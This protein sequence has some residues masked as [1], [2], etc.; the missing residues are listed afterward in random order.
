VEGAGEAVLGTGSALIQEAFV[1]ACTRI[2][3]G[4]KLIAGDCAIGVA[5]AGLNLCS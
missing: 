1:R 3:P 2:P 5:T 4:G